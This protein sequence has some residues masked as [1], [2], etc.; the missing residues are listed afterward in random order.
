[1]EL[2]RGDSSP[3][4]ASLSRCTAFRRKEAGRVG[5]KAERA[6]RSIPSN[7]TG[8]SVGAS[9]AG[10]VVTSVRRN[11]FSAPGGKRDGRKTI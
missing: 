9:N 3:R 6:G 10:R 7:R 2:E 11:K 1:M 5:E 4:K 8:A